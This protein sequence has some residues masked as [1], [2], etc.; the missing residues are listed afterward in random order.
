MSHQQLLTK[1]E[2]SRYRNSA[3]CYTNKD[4]Y[5]VNIVPINLRNHSFDA[6]A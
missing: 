3:N 2:G 1:L 4:W 5:Y 6:L